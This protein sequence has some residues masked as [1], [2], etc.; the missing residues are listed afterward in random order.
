[1]TISAFVLSGSSLKATLTL[2]GPLTSTDI[3]SGNELYKASETFSGRGED[4]I[5][6]S[7]V[8]DFEHFAPPEEED[9]D[10]VQEEE[11]PPI[12]INDPDAAQKRK[13]RRERQRKKFL[14]AKAKR[15]KRRLDI[16]KKI[17][18]EGDPVIYT[19]KAVTSGWYKMCVQATWYQVRYANL[20]RLQTFSWFQMR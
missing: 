13:E 16:Q 2:D 18:Q 8:V 9:D 7:E 1:M 3:S 12:D 6:Y 17:R 5:T 20:Y 15:D 14:E 4:Y 11:E 10:R 19:T